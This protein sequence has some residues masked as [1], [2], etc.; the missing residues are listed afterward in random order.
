MFIQ[1][2]YVLR[3][4]EQQHSSC[5][6]RANDSKSD[7]PQSIHRR[8]QRVHMDRKLFPWVDRM[9]HRSISVPARF[10]LSGSAELAK[11]TP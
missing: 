5:W 3:Q 4:T 10:A 8:V 6:P 9:V 2:T 11:I 7:G 1:Y